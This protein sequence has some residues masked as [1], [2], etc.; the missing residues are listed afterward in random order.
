MSTDLSS[1]RHPNTTAPAGQTSR[2]VAALQELPGPLRALNGLY[3]ER[4]SAC[5]LLSPEEAVGWIGRQVAVF[6]R[7][8]RIRVFAI[9]SE[10]EVGMADFVTLSHVTFHVDPTGRAQSNAEQGPLP[11]NRTIHAWL[12]GEL[13]LLADHGRMPDQNRWEPICYRPPQQTIFVRSESGKPVR[14]AEQVLLVPGR[15]KVWCPREAGDRKAGST[16]GESA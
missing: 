8:D 15:E 16:P 3:I 14:Q 2:V 11:N 9:V 1:Q 10:D 4:V 13:Q 6:L 12:T 7:H 5:R